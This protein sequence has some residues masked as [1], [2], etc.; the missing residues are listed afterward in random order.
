[1]KVQIYESARR[2]EITNPEIRAVVAHPIVRY[3][4][5]P[6]A[7]PNA[8]IFRMI[9]DPSTGPYI[10]IVAEEVS[11]EA[12]YVFHAMVLTAPVAR[13]ALHATNH[14]L[15]LTSGTAQ[16]QRPSQEKR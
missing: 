15:D 7:F 9:G 12:L 3:R 6:R 14:S 16:R 2:H 13:E 1:M 11:Q 4:L 8:I 5:A 10:E